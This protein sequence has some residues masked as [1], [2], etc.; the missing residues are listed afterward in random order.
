MVVEIYIHIHTHTEANHI[1]AKMV[2]CYCGHFYHMKLQ[3]SI[4]FIAD[5]KNKIKI[6]NKTTSIS[7]NYNIYYQFRVSEKYR[8]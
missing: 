5:L 4:P 7:Q 2:F 8:I 1:R 6:T 3:S